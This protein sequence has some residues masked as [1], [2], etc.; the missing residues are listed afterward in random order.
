MKTA[1]FFILNF[2]KAFIDEEL[3]VVIFE[4]GLAF[5]TLLFKNEEDLFANF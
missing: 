2:F 3:G 1:I 4:L 5:L